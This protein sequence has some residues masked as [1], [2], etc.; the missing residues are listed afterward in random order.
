MPYHPYN[1]KS[2][3]VPFESEQEKKD[4]ND[5]LADMLYVAAYHSALE[6]GI[7]TL[8]ITVEQFKKMKLEDIFKKLGEKGI[9]TLEVK[10]K[11]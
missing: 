4:G 2:M 8:E 6:Q 3:S 1:I 5:P 9:D 10:I 11:P 7:I